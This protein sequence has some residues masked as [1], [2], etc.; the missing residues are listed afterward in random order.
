MTLEDKLIRLSALN[1]SGCAIWFME[2]RGFMG[3]LLDDHLNYAPGTN[4]YD[5]QPTVEAVVDKLLEFSERRHDE[6]TK[7]G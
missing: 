4:V 7:R 1:M 3:C 2:G 6:S 5:Y